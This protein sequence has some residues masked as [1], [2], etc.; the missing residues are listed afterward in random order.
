MELKGKA[1]VRRARA[2][3]FELAKGLRAAGKGR[4]RTL[5][6]SFGGLARAKKMASEGRIR[7]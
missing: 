6:Y 2:A 4:R 3:H 5:S 1:P 7:N